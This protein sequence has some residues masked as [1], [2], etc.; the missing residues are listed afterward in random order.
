MEERKKKLKEALGWSRDIASNSDK[1]KHAVRILDLLTE[2][3]IA[4]AEVP[5]EVAKALRDLMAWDDSTGPCEA[6][7]EY[8]ERLLAREEPPAARNEKNGSL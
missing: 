3:G 6:I 2:L 1:E 7:N 8:L 4:G 5:D